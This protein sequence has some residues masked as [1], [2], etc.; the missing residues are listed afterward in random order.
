MTE[1]LRDQIAQLRAMAP[2][3]HAVTDEAARIVQLV[4]SFLSEECKLGLSAYVV[5]E[6]QDFDDGSDF[7]TRLEYG[8][9]DNQFRLIVSDVESDPGARRA[10]APGRRG[11]T[12][13]TI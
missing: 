3:L 4:E 9:S 13:R 8:R 12:A 2:Q 1:R 10:T 5:V 11:S 7:T 6:R